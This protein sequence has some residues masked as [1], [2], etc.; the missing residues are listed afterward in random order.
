[1]NPY[2]TA[3]NNF[4]ALIKYVE[5]KDFAIDEKALDVLKYNVYLLK[6][7]P[8]FSGELPDLSQQETT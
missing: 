5:E 4:E 7:Q 8:Q 1:M 2:V 3:V 6:I